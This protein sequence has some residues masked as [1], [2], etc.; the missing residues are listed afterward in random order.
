MALAL[1]VARVVER[2]HAVA[3]ARQHPHVAGRR[4]RLPP[5]PW[6]TRTAAPLREGT[7]QAESLRPSS[8]VIRTSSCGIASADSRISQRGACVDRLGWANGRA[9]TMA[10]RAGEPAE[11]VRRAPAET[12]PPGRA[13]GRGRGGEAGG[14][15]QEPAEDVADAGDVAPVRPGVDDVQAVRDDTE[16]DGTAR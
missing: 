13:P 1:A 14:H 2:Q 7:Y 10:A 16:A 15:E 9:D 6:L 4:P 5:E 11:A 12:R 8:I 3:V